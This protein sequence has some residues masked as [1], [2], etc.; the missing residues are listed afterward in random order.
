MCLP[1]PGCCQAVPEAESEGLPEGTLNAL[2]Y[3]LFISAVASVVGGIFTPF[4]MSPKGRTAVKFSGVIEKE[5]KSSLVC[6]KISCM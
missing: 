4:G 3:L 6:N 2:Q 5:K 1:L